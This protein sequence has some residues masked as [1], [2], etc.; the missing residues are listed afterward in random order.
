MIIRY[1]YAID[2][3]ADPRPRALRNSTQRQNSSVPTISDL[4]TAITE[5]QKRVGVIDS[6]DVGSLEYRLRKLDGI[7]IS[8]TIEPEYMTEQIQAGSYEGAT[9]P[10]YI[11]L[12]EEVVQPDAVMVRAYHPTT[13]ANVSCDVSIHDSIITLTPVLPGVTI[14]WMVK[15]TTLHATDSRVEHGVLNH[16]PASGQTVTFTV[17]YLTNGY[18]LFYVAHHVGGGFITCTA[19]KDPSGFTITPII[20]AELIEYWT[21]EVTPGSYATEAIEQPETPPEEPPPPPPPPT[22]YYYG[23]SY[24]YEYGTGL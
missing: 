6:A 5:L 4:L 13:L 10:M 7:S 24:G 17:P 14:D 1:P 15:G 23:I 19:A 16:V 21:Y 2:T 3:A 9:K 12:A 20:E 18:A 22:F 8:P 11:A